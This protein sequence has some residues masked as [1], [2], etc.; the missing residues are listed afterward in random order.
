MKFIDSSLIDQSLD[1]PSLVDV[2]EEF[3]AS[4]TCAA[5]P[6]GVYTVAN[7]E[8]GEGLL[9]VM[10]SWRT[11]T[12][13][14]TKIVSHYF[15]NPG[16][17]L[18]QLMSVYMLMDGRTGLPMAVLDGATLTRRRTA[19]A[20]ALASRYLSRGDSSRLL[21]VGTGEMIVPLAAAHGAVRPIREIQ[22]W[23]RSPVKARAAAERV[24]D[25]VDA[26]V[27]VADDLESAARWADIISCATMARSPLIR[28]DWLVAGQHI[29]LIGG[30]TP[31]MRE[32]DGRAV[33]RA[34]VFVDVRD[35]ARHEAGDLIQAEKEGQFSMGAIQADLAELALKKHEGRTDRREITLFKSV[36][37]AIEDLAA[38]S[39]VVERLGLRPNEDTGARSPQD[40]VA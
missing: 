24:G 15:E 3:F 9:F 22:V 39:L 33:S 5:P 38:A 27:S 12:L 6:R 23:G 35:G 8:I 2:L 1:Y 28:G 34:S 37:T 26:V 7:G 19:A 18:P 17:G 20:S 40:A 29:D 21:L 4:S 36:G 31:E 10:P 32:T 16:R 13:I 14:G 30:F 11:N 25:A